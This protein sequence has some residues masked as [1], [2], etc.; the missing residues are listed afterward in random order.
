MKWGIFAMCCNKFILDNSLN[1]I[2]T[3]RVF[4][5][6]WAKTSLSVLFSIHNVSGSGLWWLVFWED[7][8]SCSNELMRD[9]WLAMLLII[10]WFETARYVQSVVLLLYSCD[11]LNLTVFHSIRDLGWRNSERNYICIPRNWRE[12]YQIWCRSWCIFCW[13]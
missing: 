6:R 3:S 10:N 2:R 9:C 1:F 12:M 7:M 8:Q 13:L 5:E 4:Q 11:I